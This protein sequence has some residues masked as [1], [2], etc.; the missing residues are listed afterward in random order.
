MPLAQL[1]ERVALLG[2]SPAQAE[3]LRDM[4]RRVYSNMATLDPEG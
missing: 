2:L 3:Q 1:Y 4:L